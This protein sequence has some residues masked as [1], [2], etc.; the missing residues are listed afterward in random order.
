VP[1][2]FADTAVG[3]EDHEFEP[4][5]SN[6]AVRELN[7]RVR[8]A[9]VKFGCEMVASRNWSVDDVVVLDVGAS[10]DEKSIVVWVV[11]GL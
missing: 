11:D 9:S 7:G 6:F 4:G 8:C 10:L 5:G 1:C 2:A 3:I